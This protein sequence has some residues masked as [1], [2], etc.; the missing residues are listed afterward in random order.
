MDSLNW[1][2]LR[3]LTEIRNGPCVTIYMPTHVAAGLQGQQDAV[4]LKN[5]A[6]QAEREL[7]AR[8][9]RAPDARDLVAPLH[10]LSTDHEF[11]EARSNGL[12]QGLCRRQR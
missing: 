11:W 9:M 5:L 12:A 2:E 4:R 7:A 10:R 6:D 8:W 3:P 1:S